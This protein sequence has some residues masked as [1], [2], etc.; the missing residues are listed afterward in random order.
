MNTVSPSNFYLQENGTIP[1]NPALPVVVYRKVFS[2]QTADKHKQLQHCFEQ[3]G[4]KGIWKNGLYDY[5]HFHS[6]SHEVLGIA[7]GSAEVELGGDRGKTLVLEAGDVI[8]LPAGTGHRRMSASDNLVVIGAYPPGQE[9][10]DV[11]RSKADHHKRDRAGDIAGAIAAVPL[12]QSDPVYG[13]SGPLLEL[14][15]ARSN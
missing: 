5:H 11:C 15:S 13:A 3:S 6:A 4:W 8:V 2:E 9:D 7:S 10:Y 12:P 1:N 14:W